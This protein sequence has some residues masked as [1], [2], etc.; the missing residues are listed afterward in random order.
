MKKYLFHILPVLFLMLG[1]CQP[2][3]KLS[4]STYVFQ[5][6]D[7]LTVTLNFDE[8]SGQYYGRGINRYFGTYRLDGEKLTLGPASSTMMS[9]SPNKMAAEEEYLDRLQKTQSYQLTTDKLILMTND[10]NNIVLLIQKTTEDA[11]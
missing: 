6:T 4:D 11:P 10:G 3:P 9:G 1:A 5:A 8:Q 7:N 2:K